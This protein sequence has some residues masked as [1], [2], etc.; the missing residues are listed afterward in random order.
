VTKKNSPYTN[1][2]Q[3]AT[4]ARI[5]AARPVALTAIAPFQYRATKFHASG[6]ETTGTWMNLGWVLWRKYKEERLKK[7]MIKMIS[8]QTKWPRTKSITQAK[9]SRLLKMKWLPTPAAAFT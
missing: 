5:R 4:F 7:L 8:D 3:I 6:P 1:I 2:P 9:S